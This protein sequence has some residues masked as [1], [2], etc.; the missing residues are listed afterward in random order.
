VFDARR[1]RRQAIRALIDTNVLVQSHWLNPIVLA[2]RE[3][4]LQPLWSPLI[5]AEANRYLTWRWIKRNRGLLSNE[6]WEACSRDAKTWFSHVT[7]AFEVVEDR[8]PHAALWIAEPPDPH[9]IPLWTAAVNGRA[10]LIA[11]E[12]LKD[13]PPPNAQ[14][15][16]EHAGILLL[17]PDGLLF[18]VSQW[19]DFV[20]KQNLPTLAEAESTEAPTGPLSAAISHDASVE[21]PPAFR[22]PIRRALAK[23]AEQQEQQG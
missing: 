14:G 22:E 1:A 3:G 21:V 12:N 6:M 13:G 11:T 4:H 18:L 10:H 8:P 7:R 5:I 20:E 2:A 15:I 17:P 23:L 19:A 16:Q 9:D